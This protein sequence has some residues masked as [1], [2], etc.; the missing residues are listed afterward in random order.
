[1]S[2][3]KDIKTDIQ[4]MRRPFIEYDKKLM[5]KRKGKVRRERETVIRMW[6]EGKSYSE[7]AE[8]LNCPVQRIEKHMKKNEVIYGK[9][10]VSNRALTLELPE[11]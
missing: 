6:N 11:P 8:A 1:M 3:D 5:A 10:A 2:F 9:E 7:I 4:A